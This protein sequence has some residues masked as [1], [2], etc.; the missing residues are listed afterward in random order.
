[1]NF[2]LEATLYREKYVWKK[3]EY[4]IKEIYKR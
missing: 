1:M 4:K 2:T 3:L